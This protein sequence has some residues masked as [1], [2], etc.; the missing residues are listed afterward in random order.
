MRVSY[1]V[2]PDIAI[3][4]AALR[5]RNAI[6]IGDPTVIPTVFQQLQR[7]PLSV[8]YDPSVRDFVVG[9][10]AGVAHPFMVAPEVAIP[11]HT[12]EIPGLLTV[13]PSDDTPG[14][15]K[16]TVL[17]SC[18]MS[19]GCQAAAEFFSSPDSL[20][21]LR[22]RFR[23]EGIHGFPRAYQVVVKG[24]TDNVLLISFRYEAHRV[25]DRTVR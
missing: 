8:E 22:G 13:M 1:Q 18:A 17:L 16:R 3:R 15:N 10:R 25:L 20:R 14:S 11:G 21:E 24:R 7:A 2:L 23:Q 6:L 4:L 5:G 12:R 9:E 19:A